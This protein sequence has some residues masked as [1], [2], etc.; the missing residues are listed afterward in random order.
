MTIRFLRPAKADL[1]DAAAYYNRQREGLGDEFV[2]EVDRT[3]Q[4]I[5][6]QPNAWGHS[7]KGTRRCRVDRFNYD[8]IYFD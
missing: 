6:E 2:W 3:I 7:K 8:I 5:L 4:R 1:D